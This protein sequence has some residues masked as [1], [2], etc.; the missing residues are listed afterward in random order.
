MPVK[1]ETTHVLLYQVRGE[2][3]GMAYEFRSLKHAKDVRDS[4][5]R[6]GFPARIYVK[7]ITICPLKEDDRHD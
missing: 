6:A 2:G 4:W 5:I 3:S 1:E 7:D